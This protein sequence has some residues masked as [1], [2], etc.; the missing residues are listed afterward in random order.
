MDTGIQYH[1]RLGFPICFTAWFSTDEKEDNN[2]S[3]H[4]YVK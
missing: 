3:L 2:A 4:G 1:E